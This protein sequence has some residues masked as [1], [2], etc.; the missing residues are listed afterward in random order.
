LEQLSFRQQKV[1]NRVNATSEV[2]KSLRPIGLHWRQI[3]SGYLRPTVGGLSVAM[4]MT[5]TLTQA[6]IQDLRP[7]LSAAVN[8]K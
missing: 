7:T 6:N 8:A 4:T 3:T 1:R 5:A 2:E